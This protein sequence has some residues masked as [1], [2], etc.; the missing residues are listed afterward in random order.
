MSGT[1]RYRDY[2]WLGEQSVQPR[3]IETECGIGV[4]RFPLATP[5]LIHLAQ[6]R[7]LGESG[8]ED[9]Q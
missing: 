4:P 5:L 7:R 9:Q 2:F 8:H 1:D 3:A 6:C